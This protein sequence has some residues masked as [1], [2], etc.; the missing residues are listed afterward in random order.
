VLAGVPAGHAVRATLAY[1]IA[2][3]WLPHKDRRNRRPS[4]RLVSR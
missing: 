1:R 3:Y 4:E 2:S